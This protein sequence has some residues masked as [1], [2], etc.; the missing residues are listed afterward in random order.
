MLPPVPPSVKEGRTITGN[1]I[2]SMWRSASA[3]EV[4]IP[5]AGTA[6]PIRH[7][8]W[9]NASR[10]SALWIASAEAPISRTPYFSSVPRLARPIA[11]FNAVWPPIVGSK[12]SGRSRS[13]TSSTTSGVIGSTY[14]R[15][16]NSGSVMMVAGLLLI[17]TTR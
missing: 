9:R 13:M 10:S 3:R 8:A 7:M 1:P 15:S 12:A 14:V 4:A 2:R 5:L 17:S 16:A 11:V 6:S